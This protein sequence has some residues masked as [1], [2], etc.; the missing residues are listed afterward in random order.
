MSKTRPVLAIAFV[1]NG[2]QLSVARALNSNQGGAQLA[3]FSMSRRLVVGTPAIAVE[4]WHLAHGNNDRLERIRSIGRFAQ[5]TIVLGDLVADRQISRFDTR[6]PI[7]AVAFSPKQPIVAI[8]TSKHNHL[9]R[10]DM[11]DEETIHLWNFETN[12]SQSLGVRHTK[13][14]SDLAFSFDGAALAV[15]SFNLR[16][17]KVG[18]SEI[19]FEGNVN[20]YDTRTRQLLFAYA[21]EMG[22]LKRVALSPVQSILAVGSAESSYKPGTADFDYGKLISIWHWEDGKHLGTVELVKGPV[23]SLAFSPDG[24]TLAC[25]DGDGRLYLWDLAT[26]TNLFT[27]HTHAEAVTCLEFSSN[28]AMLASGSAGGTVIL[29]DIASKDFRTLR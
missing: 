23:E 8:G 10:G 17:P 24:K 20:I 4:T 26:R 29:V 22:G 28:G 1:E 9:L 21:H 6:F 14:V 7:S 16:R 11:L 19:G 18:D 15:T 27:M 25:G 13:D 12:E 2:I 5:R 3:K